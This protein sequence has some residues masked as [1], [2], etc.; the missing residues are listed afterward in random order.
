MIGI[1]FFYQTKMRMVGE[2][3]KNANHSL[4][5]GYYCPFPLSSYCADRAASCSNHQV[6]DEIAVLKNNSRPIGR[7]DPDLSRQYEAQQE[8]RKKESANVPSTYKDV[9]Y[10]GDIFENFD[11]PRIIPRIALRLGKRER[12]RCVC[13]GGSRRYSHLAAGNPHP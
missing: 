1:V 11:P 2:K 5:G 9:R 4:W 7:R 12:M 8:N 10:D 3:Q 13:L 6:E